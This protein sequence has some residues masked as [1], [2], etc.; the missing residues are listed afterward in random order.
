MRVFQRPEHEWLRLA[1]TADCD[2]A[3]LAM[4]EQEGPMYGV[5]FNWGY[6]FATAT[7]H[8]ADGVAAWLSGRWP[9]HLG[10]IRGLAGHWLEV[11]RPVLNALTGKSIPF[12]LVGSQATYELYGCDQWLRTWDDL[13]IA[14]PSAYY[15]QCWG[16]MQSFGADRSAVPANSPNPEF[17]L[18]DIKVS[19]ACFPPEGRLLQWCVSW[20]DGLFEDVIDVTLPSG[21]TLPFPHP[22]KQLVH[23]AFHSYDTMTWGQ[24]PF[25]LYALAKLHNL[26]QAPDFTWDAVLSFLDRFAARTPERIAKATGTYP[27]WYLRTLDDASNEVGIVGW[28]LG[29]VDRVYGG[30]P[31]RVRDYVQVRTNG[32]TPYFGTPDTRKG[33]GKSHPTGSPNVDL[34]PL[35]LQWGVIPD[36]EDFIFGERYRHLLRDRLRGGIWQE[37]KEPQSQP[38]QERKTWEERDILWL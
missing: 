35:L 15:E 10:M 37:R 5:G 19:C 12:V 33:G 36:D 17:M 27:E 16:V 7:R 2:L 4:L 21:D 28:M 1:L 25:P 22:S 23:H 18:G 29:M 32:Q 13:D 26:S 11:G 20:D 8:Q 38:S 34:P 24:A 6:V 14:V 9:E 31:Q 3:A 30:V